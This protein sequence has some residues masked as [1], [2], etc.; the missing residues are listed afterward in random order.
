MINY[1]S[2]VREAAAGGGGMVL[3]SRFDMLRQKNDKEEASLKSV[4][5]EPVK[6]DGCCLSKH[7][8]LSVL[9]WIQREPIK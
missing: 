9:K 4:D 1:E 3:V 7:F 6:L 8:V 5:I 2:P